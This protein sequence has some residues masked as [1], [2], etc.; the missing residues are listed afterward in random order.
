MLFSPWLI[1][2]ATVGSPPGATLFT[3]EVFS[4]PPGGGTCA[5]L[6]AVSIPLFATFVAVFAAESIPMFVIDV[7]AAVSPATAVAVPTSA[8]APAAAAPPDA[9]AATAVRPAAAAATPVAIRSPP[10]RDGDPP[11][12]L[13]TS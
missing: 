9:S 4:A 10:V 1:G 12:M 6:V 2:G 7:N 3:A 13:P 11:M 5:G 8:S